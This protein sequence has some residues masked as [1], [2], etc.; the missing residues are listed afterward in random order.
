MILVLC[1]SFPHPKLK[2]QK[3]FLVVSPESAHFIILAKVV[4]L[5]KHAGS[6]THSLTLNSCSE[7]HVALLSQWHGRASLVMAAAA[8]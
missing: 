5:P 7:A 4:F 6:T 2:E 1:R 3:I 8:L